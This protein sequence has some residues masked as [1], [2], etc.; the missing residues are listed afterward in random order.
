MR[1]KQYLGGFGAGVIVSA[2]VLSIASGVTKG[3][4][5]VEENTISYTITEEN[6]NTIS[7]DLSLNETTE[8]VSEVE[9]TTES[10]EETTTELIEETAEST[11]K[12]TEETTQTIT[13]STSTTVTFE[14]T[15]G[16]ATKEV[17][18]QLYNAGVISDVS[19]FSTYMYENGYDTK[20]RIGTYTLTKGDSYENIAKTITKN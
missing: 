9:T 20:I 6:G 14:I 18:N 3:S 1:L 19:A 2:S 13:T 10:V 4:A 8:A 16:T 5:A 15:T 7:S 11:T 17:F 12:A